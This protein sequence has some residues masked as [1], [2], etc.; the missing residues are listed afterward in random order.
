MIEAEVAEDEP[1]R[2]RP[3]RR[4]WVRRG[5]LALN[6]LVI[7]GC[8]ATAAGLVIGR[9]YANDIARV[10]LPSADDVAAVAPTATAAGGAPA[11]TFPR[12][13]PQAVN[14]LVAGADGRDCI[15]PD[16]PEAAGMFGEGAAGDRSD[17]IMIVRIDPEQNR[18]AVLSFQR[19]LYVTIA[20]T[21]SKRKINAAYV[22]DD[23]TRLAFTIAANFGVAADHYVQVD[24]CAFKE[25]VDALG[26]VTVPFLNAARDENTGLYVPEPGCVT[27]DGW[28]ALRYVRSRYYEFWD[29]E[30]WVADGTS[31]FGRIARQQDFA[32]RV[33]A[34]ALDTGL[35]SP[36][37]ARALI[38]ATRDYVAVD[39]ELSVGRMLAFAGVLA[40]LDPT[41]IPTYQVEVTDADVNGES[42][43]MPVMSD[44]MEAVLRIFRGEAQ[45]P[46]TATTVS[47]GADPD[48]EAP[49]DAAAF[50]PEAA[51][52]GGPGTTTAPSA[53]GD[54]ELPGSDV[55]G[56]VPPPVDC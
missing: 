46:A 2:V 38:S 9:S 4:R 3:P 20:G 49:A 52:P 47:S 27:L 14:F 18:A 23:P 6:C 56:V 15:D 26:G 53:T 44:E 50:A 45:L 10:A 16:S 41:A 39:T 48:E 30:R 5:L 22:R 1:E 40:D 43:L 42:V 19:D 24:F 54:D 31:D 35:L 55:V 32:R 12:V 37:G 11:E 17:T 33:L 51:A 36:S 7:A 25:V 13:D 21:N 29:G 8:F 28:G 34:E